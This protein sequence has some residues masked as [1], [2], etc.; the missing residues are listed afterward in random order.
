[1]TS[2]YLD[3]ISE[4]PTHKRPVYLGF[5]PDVDDWPNDLAVHVPFA[6]FAAID[7]SRLSNKQIA[8]FGRK[9]FSQGLACVSTWGPECERVDEVFDEIRLTDGKYASVSTSVWP[10]ERL[11]DALWFAVHDFPEDDNVETCP[12][13]VAIVVGNTSWADTVKRRLGDFKQFA[14]DVL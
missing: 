12:V 10:D 14:S 1:M 5:V 4:E 3:R 9:L 2:D 8:R 13:V 7:A 11:D 6:G